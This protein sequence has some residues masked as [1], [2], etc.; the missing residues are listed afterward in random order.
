MQ[1]VANPTFCT[2]FSVSSVLRRVLPHSYARA[3]AT[4][5]CGTFLT[6]TL[7]CFKQLVCGQVEPRTP[8]PPVLCASCTMCA[9]FAL[10]YSCCQLKF[11]I[12]VLDMPKPS[13]SPINTCL[14]NCL[15]SGLLTPQQSSTRPELHYVHYVAFP[16]PKDDAAQ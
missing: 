11:V 8:C 10:A 6:T 12:N 9:Q 3:L 14:L 5:R 2:G 15:C 7:L 13:P 16:V 4:F 1:R